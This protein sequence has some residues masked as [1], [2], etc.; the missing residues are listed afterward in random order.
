MS[1]RKQTY[2]E[3]WEKAIHATNAKL[4]AEQERAVLKA[5]NDAMIE[6]V[7][8]IS[9]SRGGFLPARIYR[10]Y[11]YDLFRVLNSLV[12]DYSKQAVEAT[13]DAQ[14]MFILQ[15]LGGEGNATA[16][17]YSDGIRR[18]T[19]VYSRRVAELVAKGELYKDGMGLSRRIWRVSSQAGKTIQQVVQQGLS[20]GQS[21]A[22]MAKLL[23]EFVK[24]KSRRF[25][26]SQRI[27]EILGKTTARQFEKLEYNALRL[28]RTTISH[29]ATA[30]VRQWGQ[31]NPYARKV[32]WHS[33]HAPGR[34]CQICRDL[35]GQVFKIEE[36]PFDHP[37][38][39]CYQTVYYDRSLED[40]ADELKAW[41]NGEPNEML[42]DW[43]S[44]LN[45]Q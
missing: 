28:A 40:I 20:S 5:F 42:D 35:D 33:V 2:F 17:L 27:E 22:Q 8:K 43:Y 15:A 6:L 45:I 24:P 25:W 26:D 7:G 10:D 19:A 23:E 29:S 14:M 13:L 16:S 31:I 41:S 21:A 32:Q 38:G 36:C 9:K 1:V 11:A 34:T 12:R 37:N 39:M 4:T 30:S 44:Q 3:G 18:A